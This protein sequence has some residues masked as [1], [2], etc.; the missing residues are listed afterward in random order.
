MNKQHEVWAGDFG[1]DYTRRNDKPWQPR[2]RFWREI[3]DRTKATKV[4]EVGCNMGLNLNAIRSVRPE[5]HL[6]GCDVNEYA[7]SLARAAGHR[8]VHECR[9]KDI[10]HEIG[11]YGYDLV[12]TAG[13]LIHIPPDDLDQ[14]CAAIVESST[15]W[16][17]AI[18]YESKSGDEEEVVYQGQR[19]MLWR[20][21]YGSIYWKMGLSI[22]EKRNAE[23]FDR[24]TSWLL[25]KVK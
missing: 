23:G 5:A 15:R 17:L 16:V 1:A 13:V 22:I 2:V 14:V 21:D 25:E 10:A 4:F 18:E 12:F 20:R 19:K 6:G 11:G 24:C 9:A 7:L 3:M 8:N